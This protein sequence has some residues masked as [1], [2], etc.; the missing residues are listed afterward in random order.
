M[1]ITEIH[2]SCQD[3]LR[4]KANQKPLVLYQ[5]QRGEWLFSFVSP[6]PMR[7]KVG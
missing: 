3:P 5:V 1:E 4:I 2:R 7:V 6:G